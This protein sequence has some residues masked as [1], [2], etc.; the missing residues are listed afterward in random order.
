[1]NF[2]GFFVLVCFL[3][4]KV[5]NFLLVIFGSLILFY[6]CEGE[7]FVFVNFEGFLF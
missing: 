4:L 7:C 5:F 6:W 3:S 1:V 2:G